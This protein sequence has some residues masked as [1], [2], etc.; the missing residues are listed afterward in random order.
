MVYPPANGGVVQ[1]TFKNIVITFSNSI[2]NTFRNYFGKVVE[3]AKYK[4]H[5][6]K[7]IKIQNIFNCIYAKTF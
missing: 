6:A 4:M 3:N 2:S 7:V 5:L 1:N